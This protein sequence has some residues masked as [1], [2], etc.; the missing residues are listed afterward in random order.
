M[1]QRNGRADMD[2]TFTVGDGVTMSSGTDRRPGTVI[3]VSASGKT[4]TVQHDDY[5]RIDSNGYG[6]EQVY[7][8][9]HNPDGALTTYSLRKN[10]RFVEKGSQPGAPFALYKGRSAYEDPHF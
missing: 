2:K 6:G 1:V 4:I 5:R 9:F 7:E 10:G 3:R 8:F